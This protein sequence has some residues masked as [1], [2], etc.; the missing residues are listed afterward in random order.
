MNSLCEYGDT[1]SVTVWVDPALS[2]SGIGRWKDA[3]IDRCIAPIVSS[4]QRRGVNML[5]S[6]CGHGKGIGS[7]DLVGGKSLTVHSAMGGALVRQGRGSWDEKDEH[8]DN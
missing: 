1:V 5:G 7:I 8:E 6:C 2:C 3:Q 4:L